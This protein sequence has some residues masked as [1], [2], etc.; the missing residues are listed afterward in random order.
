MTSTRPAPRGPRL[1]RP[2]SRY[3][4]SGMW[5]AARRA[6]A[7]IAAAWAKDVPRRNPSART[8]TDIG[9]CAGEVTFAAVARRGRRLHRSRA[10]TQ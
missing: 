10:V 7:S 5:R 8:L 1:V 4:L 2:A 9:L 3:S 6:A